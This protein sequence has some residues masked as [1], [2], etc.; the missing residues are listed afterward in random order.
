MLNKMRT[1]N[2][3]YTLQIAA[4]GNEWRKH[5]ISWSLTIIAVDLHTSQPTTR[6]L[7]DAQCRI[8]H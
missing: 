4:V 6:L 5:S 3:H 8:I 7:G 2:G 1:R